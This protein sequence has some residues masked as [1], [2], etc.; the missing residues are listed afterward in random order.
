MEVYSI[1]AGIEID[2][3]PINN[4]YSIQIKQAF[5]KHHEFT[6]KLPYEVIEPKRAF[7]LDNVKNHIGKVILIRLYRGSK[8]KVLT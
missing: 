6:I 1:F 3:T 4:Y 7:T 8:N 2:G 5:N